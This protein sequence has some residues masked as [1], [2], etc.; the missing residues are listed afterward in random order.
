[1]GGPGRGGRL[2]ICGTEQE[3]DRF[4]AAAP[5]LISALKETAG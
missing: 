1:V 2:Q 5:E 4:L 3:Q